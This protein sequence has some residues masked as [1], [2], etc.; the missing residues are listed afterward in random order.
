M[1]TEDI[2]T[3]WKESAA[4]GLLFVLT[5]NGAFSCV[6]SV[7]EARQ[8]SKFSKLI[9]EEPKNFAKIDMLTVVRNFKR[10]ATIKGVDVEAL[11]GDFFEPREF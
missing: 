9:Q 2:M 11:R 10:L 8:F 4:S 7:K 3:F 1:F 5:I 6:S